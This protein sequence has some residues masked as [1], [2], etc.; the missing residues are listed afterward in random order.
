MTKF[1]SRAPSLFCFRDDLLFPDGERHVGGVEQNRPSGEWVEAGRG[2]A[3][4]AEELPGDIRGCALARRE[5]GRRLG[6]PEI[7]RLRPE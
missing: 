2:A 7:Q 3:E 5:W 4:K 6:R 1:C